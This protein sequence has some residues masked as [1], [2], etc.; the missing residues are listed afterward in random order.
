MTVAEMVAAAV[1]G[2]LS[3]SQRREMSVTDEG[4]VKNCFH[5]V[6]RN[7]GIHHC[8]SRKV[9]GISRTIPFQIFG[10]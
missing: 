2:R 9:G 10:D 1:E 7:T 3:V 5:G 4:S 8:R 6:S